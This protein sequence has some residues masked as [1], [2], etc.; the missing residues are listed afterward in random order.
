MRQIQ[1]AVQNLGLSQHH[2]Q[3]MTL[4]AM[5][6]VEL[7]AHLD[8]IALE[9]P[10]IEVVR[11]DVEV[12]FAAASP[13]WDGLVGGEGLSS[14]KIGDVQDTPCIEEYLLSQVAVA[15]LSEQEL[16]V[17]R[18]L[19]G[20][21]DESGY[22]SQ[23]PEQA[24]S[25]LGAE[26]AVVVRMVELLQSLE[27]CGIGAR[28]VRESL[29]LQL[30]ALHPDAVLARGIVADHLPLLA[31][32]RVGEI[33][34]AFPGTSRQEVIEA[35]GLIRSLDPRPGAMF[36]RERTQY[37]LAD[38]VVEQTDEGFRVELGPAASYDVVLDPSFRAK[39]REG[40]D[41]SAVDWVEGK[42]R[43]AYGLRASLRQ[44]RELMLSIAEQ[45]VARQKAFFAFGP[46]HRREVTMGQVAEDLSVS[47]ST[48]SRAVKGSFVQCR[49]GVVPM[50]SL[51]S[52]STI[53]RPPAG[54]NLRMMLRDIVEG[55][56]RSCPLSD[57][58][59]A[60]EFARRGVELSRR[61]VAR[62]RQ[63]LGIP[64]AS[65]RRYR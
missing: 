38:I 21:I 60:E 12:A 61:T 52:H 47:V 5:T 10:V 43:Q 56:D 46:R 41:G 62:F 42:Y 28:S 65:E 3:T 36:A 2:L 44:R 25:S 4:L 39:V 58:K 49:W 51:F 48:V 1:Q 26:A 11:P 9:N 53:A 17:L 45:L 14:D 16:H 59:I 20:M 27:P 63:E 24:A 15:R 19:I 54:G 31:K 55:E 34:R 30:E 35:M 13:G 6:S 64:P 8:E 57:Q 32:N 37:V 50:K 22:L 40:A 18:Y 23:S 29:L 7:E 33:E